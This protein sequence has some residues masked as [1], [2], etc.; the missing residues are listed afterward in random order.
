MAEFYSIPEQSATAGEKAAYTM[1]K[2][3][4]SPE[5]HGWSNLVL[6]SVGV[7]CDFILLHP[8]N[9]MFVIEVKDWAAHQIKHITAKN[10]TVAH[11]GNEQNDKHPLLQARNAMFALKKLFV[12]KECLTHTAGPHAR[13]LIFPINY[14]TALYRITAENIL[15]RG[16]D[17][18]LPPHKFLTKNH[19]DL[20]GNI[21]PFLLGTRDVIFGC[22][23]SEAHI[24][25]IKALL[26]TPTIPTP[27]ERAPIYTLDPEQTRISRYA[28]DQQILL[29]GHAGSGKS[30][31][32][33]ERANYIKSQH[34]EWSVA[35]ICFN[36]V[37]AHYLRLLQK[38]KA[39]ID[40]TDHHEA[41]DIYDIYAW[42]KQHFPQYT[43][44]LHNATNP[45]AALRI[46]VDFPNAIPDKQYDALLI[47]E[48]QDSND[49]LLKFY[50][51]M[52]RGI[53]PSFTFCYDKR[54]SLYTQEDIAERLIQFGFTIQNEKQLVRQHRSILVLLALGFYMQHEEPETPIQN[55]LDKIWDTAKRIFYGMIDH[56]LQ[57]LNNL[58]HLIANVFTEKAA[59][60]QEAL[61]HSFRIEHMSTIAKMTEAVAADIRSSVNSGECAYADWL[62]VYPV[63]RVENFSLPHR[64]MGKFRSKGVPYLYIDSERGESFVPPQD[65]Q[66]V[67]DNR[68]GAQLALDAVKIMTI[69][70]SKGLD[71]KRVAILA[72]DSLDKLS[73]SN[74]QSL[75]AKLGYVGITRAKEH[76]S[77]YF[78][79]PDSNA[80]NIL[81]CVATGLTSSDRRGRN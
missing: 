69:H 67:K 77:I 63:R 7:E 55:T 59:R 79:N 13:K 26:G 18:I 45:E 2:C 9:G 12:S 20:N 68:R 37:M 44:R 17:N 62:V 28:L 75:A 53:N 66:I 51:I 5:Y 24:N 48:G 80:V 43:I 65:R 78:Q 3:R 10:I 6:H 64:L 36:A 14:C 52:L 40:A 11:R 16:W 31:V 38:A 34:P 39:P 60:P 61:K 30:V 25:I 32:L 70:T 81:Q 46:A 73:D 8:Q 4:L 19:F 71:A 54:Q 57:V 42:A 1:L 58:A 50:R 74:H 23:L 15:E 76:C 72:F 27:K 21:E 56:A 47:D 29:E 49:T 22:S 33:L 35:I 41:I